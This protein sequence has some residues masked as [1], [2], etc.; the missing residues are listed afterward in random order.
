M[1]TQKKVYP[2]QENTKAV[3]CR[4][5]LQEYQK[6]L[7]EAKKRNIKMNDLLISKIYGQNK[8]A[9]LL[10][11]IDDDGQNIYITESSFEDITDKVIEYFSVVENY[12]DD[13]INHIEW[14]LNNIDDIWSD[15]PTRPK[16]WFPFFNFLDKNKY[17]RGQERFFQILVVLCRVY[18]MFRELKREFDLQNA[19]I[20]KYEESLSIIDERIN[21]LSTASVENVKNQISILIANKWEHP[22]D[23]KEF[24]KEIMP[25]LKELE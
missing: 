4:I 9:S 1:S 21:A 12:S 25:L 7:D 5:P 17:T 11:G 2:S 8:T 19:S 24:R 13:A 6:L 15:S 10:S 20:R 3:A 18:N 23:R 14:M 22:T 16:V